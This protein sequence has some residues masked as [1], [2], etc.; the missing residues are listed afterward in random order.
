MIIRGYMI[1]YPYQWIS[2]KGMINYHL[3]A[4]RYILP[5][6]IPLIAFIPIRYYNFEH[7]I[8][9]SSIFAIITIVLFII[10]IPQIL[11]ESRLMS[12]GL[13]AQNGFGYQ[14][15]EVYIAFAFPVLCQ[16]YIKNKTWLLN[17]FALLLSLIMYMIAARRGASV[18]TFCLLAFSIY[19]YLKNT[20][21]TKR[22]QIVFI[23]IIVTIAILGLLVHTNAIDYL[24]IRGLE[25]SRSGVDEAMLSQMSLS[26]KIFG[27]GLNGRYYYPVTED[28][29]WNPWGGWRYGSETG[30]YNIVLKGGYI[31]VINY[32]ILL[33]I[34]AVK[35][36]FKS[37]NILCKA[38]GGYLLLSLI[39]LIPF[40]WQT[41]NMKFLIIWMFI[42]MLE[43][44][45]LR[46]MN[47]EQIYLTFFKR[48]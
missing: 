15:A 28:D 27:K 7:I 12:M 26:E 13:D 29:F 35:G 2:F 17:V 20:K 30:F 4:P 22:L 41:F 43:S 25:D 19:L 32:I 36:I 37:R 21:K 6:I 18:I 38:G 5:Y 47:D 39:D 34:P 48:S 24:L 44:Q 33:L 3:F 11:N 9:L 23:I 14:F 1:N 46:K 31:M 45:T 40:G 16:K 8:R 42:S 10:Y